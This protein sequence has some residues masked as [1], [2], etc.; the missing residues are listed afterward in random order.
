MTENIRIIGT[1]KLNDKERV[2]LTVEENLVSEINKSLKE[3]D[4]DRVA[5]LLACSLDGDDI[6]WRKRVFSNPDF[7]SLHQEIW[8]K[9]KPDITPEF[10]DRVYSFLQ[11]DCEWDI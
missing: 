1:L 10:R 11:I 5:N 4:L 8:N 6:E 3:N 2:D 7:D 9:M